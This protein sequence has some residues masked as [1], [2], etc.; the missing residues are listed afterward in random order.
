VRQAPS[1]GGSLELCCWAHSSGHNRLNRL[2]SKALKY[3]LT[4]WLPC[5][6]L[7]FLYLLA[8]I[9][10]TSRYVLDFEV[11]VQGLVGDIPGGTAEHF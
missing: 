6:V 3:A 10:T 5:S 2:S 7:R 8:L 9:V 4:S 1:I 11:T